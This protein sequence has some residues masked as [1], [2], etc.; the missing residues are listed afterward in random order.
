MNTI[1]KRPSK[2][3]YI[4][5][6]NKK[7]ENSNNEKLNNSYNK[8]NSNKKHDKNLDNNIKQKNARFSYSDKASSKMDNVMTSNNGNINVIFLFYKIISIFSYFY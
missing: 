3:E 1:I 5:L 6:N 8:N 7:P 4:G 2:K